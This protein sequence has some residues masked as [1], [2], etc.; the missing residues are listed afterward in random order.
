M[1]RAVGYTEYQSVLAQ[2]MRECI[3][4]I[5][6]TLATVDIRPL[7]PGP[8]TFSNGKLTVVYDQNRFE[9]TVPGEGMRKILIAGFRPG[10][11][12]RIGDK[13]VVTV[14]ANGQL[15]CTGHAGTTLVGQL[16]R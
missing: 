4:G 14:A 15:M 9:V 3:Y 12:Y 6:L 10:A 8:W 7:K 1:I 16:V 11:I 5:H 13:D 2:L